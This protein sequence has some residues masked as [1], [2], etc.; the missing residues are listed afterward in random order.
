MIEFWLNKIIFSKSVAKNIKAVF[1][2][3]FVYFWGFFGWFGLFLFLFFGCA[4]SLYKSRDG[5][6]AKQRPELLQWKH[7]ILNP[8]HH[9][10]TPKH[11][12][13]YSSQ[14]YRSV[15]VVL[16]WLIMGESP[17]YLW[18]GRTQVSWSLAVLQSP[19]SHVVAVGYLLAGAMGWLC[20]VISHPLAG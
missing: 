8:L 19:H 2:L 20:C 9:K 14:V 5:T 15:G 16:A 17:K 7:W 1:G 18:A 3:F 6:H 4:H 11:N 10:G 13:L 12:L